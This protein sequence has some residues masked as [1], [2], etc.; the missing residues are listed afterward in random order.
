MKINDDNLKSIILNILNVLFQNRKNYD[1]FRQNK[2]LV[3]SIFEILVK[4]GEITQKSE[5]SLVTSCLFAAAFITHYE[6]SLEIYQNLLNF[7]D[8]F[9]KFRQIYNN[10]QSKIDRL[11]MINIFTNL[12]FLKEMHH[13][14]I[15][16]QKVLSIISEI[17][18]QAQDILDG[19]ND[20]LNCAINFL[21]NISHNP[22]FHT[23]IACEEILGVL[24]K[25]FLEGK[26]SEEQK[27]L[28]R[29]ILT[30]TSFSLNCHEN[31]IKH[32]LI[33]IC[34]NI[35]NKESL[36]SL[37]NIGL[38]SK[39]FIL[40]ENQKNIINSL[41][42]IKECDK[43][44]QTKL[45]ESASHYVLENK[46]EDNT[47]NK[48]LILEQIMKNIIVLL[49]SKSNFLIK[50]ISYMLP[51]LAK[52]NFFLNISYNSSKLIEELVLIIIKHENNLIKKL[53]L[54]TLTEL[55]KSKD[56]F[57]NC[58]DFYLYL[59]KLFHFAHKKLNKM[60]FSKGLFNR[61]D[62]III[63][64][65]KILSH[66]A[67]FGFSEVKLKDILCNKDL[68]NFVYNSLKYAKKFSFNLLTQTICTYAN[69]FQTQ[70]LAEQINYTAI[71]Q[72]IQAD[73][74]QFSR[75]NPKYEFFI[76][77]FLLS[78][79]KSKGF[80]LK[81]FAAT[82]KTNIIPG[83]ISLFS[84]INNNNNVNTL[85]NSTNQILNSLQT[86]QKM[87]TQ[88]DFLN[89]QSSG[90]LS[91]IPSFNQES[92]DMI[93]EGENSK[94]KEEFAVFDNELLNFLFIFMESCLKKFK[95]FEEEID[96]ESENSEN[97]FMLL[98]AN[99]SFVN[100]NHKYIYKTRIIESLM[101]Y[102]M[103]EGSLVRGN[104]NLA[105]IATLNLA[106]NPEYF[107]RVKCEDLF[108]LLEKLNIYNREHLLEYG[109]IL[110]ILMVIFSF[111]V[112]FLLFCKE[113]AVGTRKI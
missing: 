77:G 50:N 55:T 62:Y 83:E 2:E 76:L 54:Q 52:N 27:T 20:L 71:L 23:F 99:L 74:K 79:F 81:D 47:E 26:C 25:G 82:T 44:L 110:L 96:N 10:L 87:G 38:N 58:P 56:F 91:R 66:C 1:Y 93:I 103:N 68:E 46:S 8:F 88:D 75:K 63:Y 64:F 28:I 35:N 41:E 108:H 102:L 37:I 18:V 59:E 49:D 12:V 107:Q 100:D 53:N 39:N 16:H 6:D 101:K 73:Y 105:L 43:P 65:L 97:L 22:N 11:C 32:K 4:F 57:Q 51:L 31:L 95:K 111:F 85:H 60:I 13:L 84:T 34:N 29:K 24:S 5:N 21:A 3:L 15:K 92:Q 113:R 98:L 112:S 72:E 7:K 78:L 40:I 36:I 14:V 19:S 61:H 48:K 104:Y 80:S 42:L 30:N 69:F 109:V 33:E 90:V 70:E 45:L 67:L 106:T 17:F 86:P 94:K 89:E 9:S